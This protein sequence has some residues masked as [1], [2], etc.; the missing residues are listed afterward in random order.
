MDII[1]HDV[2]STLKK[3]R[4]LERPN[5]TDAGKGTQFVFVNMRSLYLFGNSLAYSEVLKKVNTFCCLDGV[6]PCLF[7]GRL[8]GRGRV[9]GRDFLRA[10]IKDGKNRRFFL[11]AASN[12]QLEGFY[13][14]LRQSEEA[15]LLSGIVLPKRGLH[16]DVAK[17][18]EGMGPSQRERL[19]TSDLVIAGVSSP[20]Q[21]IFLSDLTKALGQS[22]VVAFAGLGAAIDDVSC[23]T[24]EPPRFI[25]QIGLE[26]LFRF[27]M[28]PRRTLRR[29]FWEPLVVLLRT[30]KVIIK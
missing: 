17:I 29:V 15:P 10:F 7:G 20:K 14:F 25:Q 27:V 22:D 19:R 18:L 23:V 2:D 8:N 21:D 16:F 3:I 5:A 6:G 24:R 4:S 11:F 1:V 28:T 9:T 12:R 13:N 26:F 30:P